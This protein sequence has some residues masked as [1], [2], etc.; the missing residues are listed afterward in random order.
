MIDL[1]TTRIAL[2][3]AENARRKVVTHQLYGA[4]DQLT[5]AEALLWESIKILRNVIN[6][7]TYYH[8]RK[9]GE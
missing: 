2:K 7:E 8:I 9:L 3:H 6:P 1:E 5:Q 4:E